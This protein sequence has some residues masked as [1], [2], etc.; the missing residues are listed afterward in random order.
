MG[1][2]SPKDKDTPHQPPR[3]NTPKLSHLFPATWCVRDRQLVRTYVQYVYHAYVDYVCS[4]DRRRET[5]KDDARM[6]NGGEKFVVGT[7]DQRIP[8]RAN[9]TLNYTISI[10][11]CTI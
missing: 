3:W 4:R 10:I 8:I 11:L 5:P 2:V 7:F 1:G 6:T 9:F